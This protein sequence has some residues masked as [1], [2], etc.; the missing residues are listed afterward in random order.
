[1]E[2]PLTLVNR[3][4]IAMILRIGI[5]TLAANTRTASGH[6]PLSIKRAMPLREKH[7]LIGYL[8]PQIDFSMSP[9]AMKEK[10]PMMNRF[11]RPFESKRP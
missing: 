3:N 6:K 4:A 8:Q 11:A 10:F 9:Y 5:A 1:M 7:F 2:R